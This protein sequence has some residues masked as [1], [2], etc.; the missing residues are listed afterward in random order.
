MAAH[1]LDRWLQTRLGRPYNAL[2]GIGL[3]VEIIR[4]LAEL[5]HHA[6]LA[7]R[8][9][10]IILLVVMNIALLI[11]QVGALSHHTGR[12]RARREA[13]RSRR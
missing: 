7:P 1:R 5:P 10:G 13:R 8:L 6:S 9:A 12:I 4:R 2:L 3:T 11:H